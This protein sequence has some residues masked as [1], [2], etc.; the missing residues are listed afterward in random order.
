M[1]PLLVA[2]L[3]VSVTMISTWAVSLLRRDASVV[4]VAWGLGFAVLA[5]AVAAT[6]GAEGA[7]TALLLAMVSAWGLRLAVHL[8]RRNLREGE[9]RRYREMRAR[10]P[11]FALV[12]LATVFAL[13]GVAMWTVALPVTLALGHNGGEP[14]GLLALAGAA[15]WGIGVTFEATADAQLARFRRDPANAG[16]VMDRGLWRYSRHPNYFG[17]ACTWW[18]IGL[19]AIEADAGAYAW[20]LVGPLLMTALLLRVSGVPLLES[21]LRTSRPG[22]EAYVR[23]TSAFFPLPPKRDAPSG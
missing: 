22:Y 13:Q 21:H 5:W 10:T 9:D 18:G 4:D 17:D 12:S 15:L 19:V 8:G 20:A 1:P 23:R 6:A 16:G 3:A 11:R 7:R 2:A 14:L